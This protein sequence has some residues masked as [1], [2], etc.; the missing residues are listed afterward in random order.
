MSKPVVLVIDDKAGPRESLRMILKNRYDVLLADGPSAGL[1]IAQEQ[2]PDVVFCDIKMPEMEGPEVLRRLKQIDPDIEV[3]LVTAYAAVDTAQLALRYGAIDY[4][5]KPFSIQDIMLVADRALEKRQEAERNR[6]LLAQLEPATQMLSGQLSAF[7]HPAGEAD[8][9]T[10]YHNLTEAHNSIESQLSK[11]AKLNAIGEVAAEV[12]HDV[13]N[14]LTSILLRIEILLMD[15]KDPAELNGEA[16]KDALKDILQA[17]SDGAQAVQRIQS[18]SKADPYEAFSPLSINDIATDVV[19]MAFGQFQSSKGVSI[20]VETTDVPQIEGS[21]TGLRTAVMNIVINARQAL[22]ETGGH[23]TLRT[24]VEGDYVFISVHDTGNG[25]P[26]EVLPL[27]T[28]PFFTT[29]GENG[30]GLGLSVAR[31]VIGVHEGRLE[32]DSGD[33]NG[34]TVTIRLPL[35]GTV[36]HDQPEDQEEPPQRKTPEVLVIEDDVEM[37]NGIKLAIG[38]IG[39]TVE[40][41]QQAHEGLQLFEQYLQEHGETPEIVITD[42]HMPGLLGTEVARRIKRLAPKTRVILISGYVTEEASTISCPHVDAIIKKPFRFRDL[43]THLKP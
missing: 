42:L 19:N 23:V 7:S 6:S 30:S 13:R 1:K 10:I 15:L 24:G 14:F 34:T 18:I 32:F 3:A 20:S 2:R 26:A 17:A 37:L 12:A 35:P 41:A 43:L 31:K 39:L 11:I 38:E 36:R 25:I 22:P 29:K 28:E 4:I 27:I 9:T 40:A 33:G 21:P 8:Q 16:V 5:T